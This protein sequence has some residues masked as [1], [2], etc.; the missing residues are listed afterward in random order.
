MARAPQ[1]NSTRVVLRTFSTERSR[2]GPISA[3]ERTCVPPQAL[4]S[5]E[6][7][8]RA[9]L[10]TVP[11]R[12]WSTTVGNGASQFNKR[13]KEHLRSVLGN[14]EAAGGIEG[15]VEAISQSVGGRQER[16]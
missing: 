2:T 10:D 15:L 16:G 14:S 7:Q 4:R 5:S 9:M 3:V 6:Q 12:I 1:T 8:L 13:Y 11:V